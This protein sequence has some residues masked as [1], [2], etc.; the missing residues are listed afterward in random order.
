[1]VR[2]LIAVSGAIEQM[3]TAFGEQD[4]TKLTTAYTE[5]LYRAG[6]R[7]VI[8]PVTSPA[9]DDLMGAMDGLVLTGGGD[10][11]PAFYGEK[12]DPS[13]YGVRPDRDAFVAALYRDAVER[14]L[15]ILAICRGMQLVNVLR[16]GTLMQR[17]T[18]DQHHWQTIPADQ[19]AHDIAVAAPS[20]LAM[21]LGE[22]ASV[23]SYHHQALDRVGAGLCVSATCGLVIEAVEASDADLIAVQWHPEQMAATNAEQ[24]RLFD[25][26]VNSA[27]SKAT[28]GRKEVTL[29]PTR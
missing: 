6:G 24:Q 17:L 3:P 15:P 10:I 25:A 12:A 11:D 22:F 21:T 28:A 16:G 29:C 9:L 18:D 8:V 1:M 14:G 23:N 13:V 27:K 7:P 19:P 5:A 20:H 26:F 4:C 2:P